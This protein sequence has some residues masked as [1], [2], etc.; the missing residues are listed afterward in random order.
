[1]VKTTNRDHMHG[2]YKNNIEGYSIW[3]TEMVMDCSRTNGGYF[4]FLAFSNRWE[5]WVRYGKRCDGNV[6]ALY[7]KYRENRNYWGRCGYTNM[8]ARNGRCILN[9]N[10]R[11][12][13]RVSKS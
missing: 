10:I 3:K 6:G 8:I 1:M 12:R 13:K 9:P 4:E 7:L 11:Y 2:F 5:P